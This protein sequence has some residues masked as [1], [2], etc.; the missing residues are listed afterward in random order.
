MQEHHT[1]SDQC[2]AS[3][4]EPLD[5][6]EATD[7][8]HQIAAHLH[9]LWMA[10]ACLDDEDDQDAIGQV[11][12][13]ALKSCKRAM[14]AL[15]YDGCADVMQST[16]GQISECSSR[17]RRLLEKRHGGSRVETSIARREGGDMIIY[18]FEVHPPVF[19]I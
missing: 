15:R 4:I 13:D 5:T 3:A 19:G 9:I 12:H 10:S 7:R 2:N 6:I 1:H 17:L 16:E 8:L 14:A 11:C 18:M